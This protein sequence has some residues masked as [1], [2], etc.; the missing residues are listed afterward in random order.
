MNYLDVLIIIPLVYA[1]IKGFSNGVIKEITG[2]LALFLGVY[3]AINFSSYLTPKI[4]VFLNGNEEFVAITSFTILFLFTIIS[5][6]FFGYIV[7][8]FLK[9]LAL[10]FVSRLFGV[11]FGFFKTV[12]ILAVLLAVTKE[13]K[14]IEKSI[15]KKSTLFPPLERV[16]KVIIP[17]I[18]KHKKRIIEATKENTKKA[19]ESIEQTFSVE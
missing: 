18:K 12:V 8:S 10:G 6:K 15:Q 7:D 16:S 17:E 9:V 5:I 3:I 1:M 4:S 11:V 13:Y 19:K 14:L 2:I